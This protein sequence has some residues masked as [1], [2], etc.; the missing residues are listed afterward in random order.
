MEQRPIYVFTALQ[1]ECIFYFIRKKSL[2]YFLV[3]AFRKLAPLSVRPYQDQLA[4]NI[5]KPLDTVFNCT[6]RST[7]YAV[8]DSKYGRI[9]KKLIT[10]P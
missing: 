2:N 6:V 10:C 1:A 8:H 9:M 5:A 7:Q 3:K 4:S